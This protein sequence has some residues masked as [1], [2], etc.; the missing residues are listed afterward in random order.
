MFDGQLAALQGIGIQF[1]IEFFIG[2][3]EV[4]QM[5]V[6]LVNFFPPIRL[7]EEVDVVADEGQ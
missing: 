4:E 7:C 5:Q 3:N 6:V 2:L 1:L